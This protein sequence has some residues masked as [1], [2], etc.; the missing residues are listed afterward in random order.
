MVTSTLWSP[1]FRYLIAI[2]VS[3]LVLSS[4]LMRRV[5]G[6]VQSRKASRLHSLTPGAVADGLNHRGLTP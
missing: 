5:K 4:S 2:G 1:R 3:S 6:K